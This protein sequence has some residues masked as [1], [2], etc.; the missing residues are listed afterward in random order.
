M[1]RVCFLWLLK[2]CK[3]KSCPKWKIFLQKKGLA[4]SLF[5]QGQELPW[6]IN[7]LGT[8]GMLRF[9]LNSKFYYSC[10]DIH[11]DLSYW[12]EDLWNRDI[13]H[14]KY[15]IISTNCSQ[16][17]THD[18]S[19]PYRFCSRW[20]LIWVHCHQFFWGGLRFYYWFSEDFI[21]F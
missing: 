9:W 19:E 2:T 17:V 1:H 3:F 4:Q 13:I 18:N 8:D 7:S 6:W 5:C 21:V 20:W 12:G 14:F 16:V 15:C 11:Q 10:Y